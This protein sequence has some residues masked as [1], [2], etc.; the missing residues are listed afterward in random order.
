MAKQRTLKTDLARLKAWASSDDVA[1]VIVGCLVAVFA[2]PTLSVF[3]LAFG[4]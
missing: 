4:R 2:S 1:P 3:I